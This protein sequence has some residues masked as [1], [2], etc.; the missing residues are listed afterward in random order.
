MEFSIEGL[1]E[2]RQQNLILAC[3]GLLET[4]NCMMLKPNVIDF[5]ETFH[6]TKNFYLL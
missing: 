3:T 2:S 5:S 6:Y 4:L 1:T